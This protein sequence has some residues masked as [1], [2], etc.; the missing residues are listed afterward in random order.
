MNRKKRALKTIGITDEIDLPEAEIFG[1]PCKID[2][3]ADTSSIHCERIRIKEV[4]GKEFLSFRLL[5]RKHPLYNGKEILTAVFKEK[6][7]KSS[8]GDYEFRYQVKMP[9]QL[10]GQL[11]NVSFNLSNRREM[12]YPVLLGRRFLK[13]RFLVDVSQSQLSASRKRMSEGQT[14]D[15]PTISST[16]IQ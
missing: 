16:T 4:N 11:F 6:K 2:T 12:K 8:F 7:V 14:T 1:L 3:G 13:N 9:V 5:D 15:Q 10:F